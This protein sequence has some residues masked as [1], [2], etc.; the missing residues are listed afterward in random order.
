MWLSTKTSVVIQAVES[1]KNEGSHLLNGKFSFFL[2][3]SFPFDG[4]MLFTSGFSGTSVV[5]VE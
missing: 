2:S 5:P 1:D 3:A 4:Q